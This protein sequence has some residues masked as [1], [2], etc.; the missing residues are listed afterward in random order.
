MDLIA[1]IVISFIKSIIIVLGLLVG[2][3]YTTWFERKVCARFQIRYGPNRAGPFGLLQPVADAVKAIFKEEIIPAK[4][5][6]VLYFIAP[7]LSMA[8]ALLAFAVVPVGRPIHLFGRDIPLYLADVNIGVLYLMAVAGLATY[9]VVLGGWSSNNKY[10]LL[11]ALRT[12]AQMISYELPMG[13]ALLSILLLAGNLSLV[14]I[15]E[16]QGTLPL[17]VLQPVAFIIYLICSFAEAGRTPF[18]LPE[19]E[20]ELVAGYA[21]EYGGIKFPLFFMAEYIHTITASA[22]ITTLFLGGWQGPFADLH[23]LIPPFWF[24]VKTVFMI[25]V[26][27]W[28]RSSTP[29]VRYD[30]LMKFCWKFLAPLA[31]INLAVT[32]IA[33]ALLA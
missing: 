18:D 12:A 32:A 30:Q 4:A 20:N 17:I 7:G 23:P 11:G 29:R 5:D 22:V 3:A 19:T 21:T 27:V 16:Y 14:R 25:F 24:F 33:V 15:V 2:F 31:L 8:A 13:L 28:V 6:K 1:S 26:F 10:S 9:G